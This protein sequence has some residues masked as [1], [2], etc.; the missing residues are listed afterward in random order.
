[1]RS[2][3]NMSA[4]CVGLAAMSMRDRVAIYP[5]KPPRSGGLVFVCVA[6]F[7]MLGACSQDPRRDLELVGAT[8]LVLAPSGSASSSTR[9]TAGTYL[10][11]AHE[12][13]VD[14]QL[15]VDAG[16]RH[17]ALQDE[18][19]RHGRFF[20]VVSLTSPGTIDVRAASKD[21]FTKRG[22]V[23]VRLQ[24]WKD[25]DP[26][27]PGELE[28]GFVA[29]G[30]ADEQTALENRE[31]RA[32]AADKLNEAITLFEAAGDD[33]ARAEAAYTLANLQY[34]AR[35][36]W[37]AAVR[38]TEIANDAYSRVG[39][40]TG[41]Q[42]ASTLRAAAEI[43]IALAMN[44][45]TQRAEQHAL[46]EAADRKLRAA[47]DYF[48]THNLPIRAEYAV[49][50]RGV[51]ALG[52]GDYVAAE[53]L[54]GEA[55]RMA[56]ANQDVGE[57]IKSLQNL[58]YAHN[59]LGFLAEAAKEYQALLPLT[60]RDHQPYEYANVLANYGFTLI[61]L[62]DFDR[63]LELHTEALKLFSRVD[64][65]DERA[66][67]LSALGG[68]YFRMGDAD[69]ALDTLR[70]A[71]TAQERLADSRGLASTLRLAGNAAAAQGDHKTALEYLRRSEGL[72]ANPTGVARTGILIASELRASGDLKQ[73][74][75]ELA[76]LMSSK[77]SLVHANAVEERGRVRLA[78]KN[79]T[80]AIADFRAADA[81]Y[82]KLGLDFDRIDTNT[83]LSRA[84]LAMNDVKGASAAA[85]EA[86]SIV[87]RIRVKSANPEW[88]AHFLSSRYSP[89]EVRIAAD[90][91][92]APDANAAAWRSFLTAERVRARSLADELAFDA[93]NAGQR[94]DP[95]EAALRS[96]L[97]AQQL[98]LETRVQRGD[99]DDS[100]LLDLRRAIEETRAQIDANRVRTGGVAAIDDALPDSL[101]EIQGKL[102][103]DTAVLAYFVGDESAHAWL[104]DRQR[105]QHA[106]LASPD[107][108]KRLTRDLLAFRGDA[109]RLV[110]NERS[111]G[112]ML[113]AHLLDGVKQTRLLII[114]DGPLNSV[115]FAALPVPNGGGDLLVDRFVISYAPSLMLAMEQHR[116]KTEKASEVVVVSDPVYAPDD[117][118]LR[119]ADNGPEG[120]YR[121]A[122]PPSN[123]QLTRL[124]YSALEASAVIKALGAPRTIQLSGFDANPDR[125]LEL[126]S[127][128]LAVLHFATHAFARRDSPEQSALFLSEYT[129]AG[130]L[131]DDSRLT[132]AD[133]KQHGLRANVVVLSGCATG[134]GAELRGEGVL[135]LTYGF[136]ANGS[137]AVVAALWPIE[138]ASTARF[139]SEF[140][141]A[142]RVSGRAPEA[143]RA[144]QLRS[145]KNI[146]AAVWSSFVVRADEFP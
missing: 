90:L 145:R 134:D 144:A 85:D 35:D 49:N 40:A 2:A 43:E 96:K 6:A 129:P 141:R 26:R 95:Q 12:V 51:R 10:I 3:V 19:P 108:I 77:N 20:Q 142:F 115:P 74:D 64:D 84:L 73:A 50:M 42:N 131:L 58:A 30:I 17:H 137:G 101:A 75:D 106:T 37:S 24:R 28:R 53:S 31:S 126:A 140:Y 135:G 25:R 105:L 52:V 1:M 87:S 110:E 45:G 104:L 146:A 46:Y 107:D 69:R 7:A 111:L 130:T 72:D 99:A 117:R 62:G 57:Q 127:K 92:G 9:V 21:H 86:V 4:R 91:A 56:K 67:E 102:P 54:L 118:R 94:E 103:P 16:A 112:P 89:F 29:F 120:T 66:S 124:P 14:V 114:A 100:T 70:A 132:A 109:A 98:R 41:V 23:E 39:D 136:L 15:T 5:E 47:A 122:P 125:V 13:D 59:R 61:P 79:L 68:L 44:A 81:E 139:M 138:D 22:S 38:A 34:L 8:T 48:K 11:E 93:S 97:T 133:I 65:Q 119:L 113:F 128:N 78:E 32:K 80:G 123:N 143:L 60:D 83:D 36:E 33:A 18:V 27:K 76:R 63:A 82:S 55:V 88:R 71:V 116:R 121:G